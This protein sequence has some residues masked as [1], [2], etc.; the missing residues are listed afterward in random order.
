MQPLASPA[1]GPKW[2]RRREAGRFAWVIAGGGTTDI[3]I[4]L[5]KYAF[6]IPLLISSWRQHHYQRQQR[7]M[8]LVMQNQAEIT[9]RPRLA[10]PSRRR[11]T[12]MKSYLFRLRIDLQRRFPSKSSFYDPG[13]MEEIIEIVTEWDVCKVAHYKEVA[14]GIVWQSGGSNS[15]RFYFSQ[16][17][18]TWW[19]G[20]AHWLSQ[21]AS[22]Q[23]SDRKTVKNTCTRLR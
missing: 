10:K 14:G 18:N 5:W 21:R 17:L 4:F 19:F 2:W 6:G 13:G 12:Q 3:A 16:L 15:C 11:Q 20:Y 1:F 23:V 7:R 9:S 8:H 22:W